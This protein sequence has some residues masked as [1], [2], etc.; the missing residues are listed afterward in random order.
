MKSGFTQLSNSLWYQ[1]SFSFTANFSFLIFPTSHT[2]MTTPNGTPIL[3][4]TNESQLLTI[5]TAAQAPLKLTSSN[6][7]S[8]KIQFETLFIG[9]DLLGYIDG[10]KPCPPKTL[11]TNNVDTLN[12]A[13]TLWIRQ[14]QLILNALI[15]SLSPTIISFI[16]RA[17]TSREAWTILANTY[18]KPSRGRIKQVKNLLKNPSKGTMTVTDFLHSL[19]ART[20][21]LA[22]LGAPME[23]ED[24]T[25][26]ILDGLGDEYKELVRVVQAHDTSISFDE[27]HEKLLSFEAYL[28][29][30]TKSEVNLPIT[31][32]PTNRNNPMNTNSRLNKT[33][34]NWRPNHSNS[35]GNTGWR[36]PATFHTRPPMA[37]HSGT[38]SRTN[39]PPPRPY[40]GFCQICGI[41]GYTAK[42][43]PSFQLV[44]VQSSTT[45]ATPPANF[46]TPWQ[47]RAYY[48]ANTATNNPSWLLDSGASHHVT[49]DLNNLSLHA[50][51]TGSD[52]VMIGDGTGL[53]ISHTGSASLPSSTTRFTLNDV[54]YDLHTGAILLTGNT[55]D[56]VYEW[57]TAQLASSPI[58]AFSHVKTTSSNGIIA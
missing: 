56:G 17:N 26:K 23:E 25:E 42:R 51:Y 54:L 43:C 11:T 1:S 5:N 33:N 9:Y 16:A 31:A 29:A 36:P 28:L 10:S 2:V 7:L 20:D 18:A 47:P 55:K 49:T 12:P 15:G 21:E 19:R 40:Q 32:N 4:T 37:T 46:A 38:P 44:P 39:R 13:Y 3:P 35:S 8:W 48:A 14:D 52:D 57:S 27:L 45:S 24:L 22:I 30:N 53:L 58:L 34:T 50:P 41:Q 6:Y